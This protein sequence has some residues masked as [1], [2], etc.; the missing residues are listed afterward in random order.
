MTTDTYLVRNRREF[1]VRQLGFTL[2]ELLVV[3]AIIAILAAM[4]LPA[5]SKAKE[6][7]HRAKCMSNE[8]QLGIALLMY[9]NDNK[10]FLPWF[11]A[12]GTWLWDLGKPAADAIVAAGAQPKVFYCPGI[13]ASVNERDL[14]GAGNQVSWWNFTASRRIVGFAFL[15]ER[16]GTVL[17]SLGGNS[18]MAAGLTQGGKFHR[19]TTN[20]RPSTAVLVADSTISD[21][22]GNFRGVVSG[23]VALDGLQKSAHL[24]KGVASGANIL[25]LDGHVGWRRFLQGPSR[26]TTTDVEGR[27]FIIKMY[28][29]PDGRAQF[30]F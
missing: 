8:R 28:N 15:I 18:Q 17:G 7:A 23:N 20:P 14:F 2:I 10:E 3:I 1:T 5:L 25:Y 22:T 29:T 19:K 9:A 16:Q 6:R 24:D 30:W 11:E 27:D 4:L 12:D 13:T 26:S 21:P